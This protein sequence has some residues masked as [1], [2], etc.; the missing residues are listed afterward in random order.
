M[1]KT[2]EIQFIQYMNFFEK[3]IGLR[4][5]HC[6]SFNGII[7]FVVNPGFVRRAIG[8]NASNIKRLTEKLRRRVRIIASPS[9]TRDAEKFVCSLIYPIQIKRFIIEGNEASIIAPRE[10]R[11]MIIG[12]NKVKLAELENILKEYF[13]IK[14]LR[15]I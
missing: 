7:F 3:L 6:F 2:L 11:A 1:G 15:V 9:S 8:K 10:A 13:G 4:T 5:R 12:R 14:R